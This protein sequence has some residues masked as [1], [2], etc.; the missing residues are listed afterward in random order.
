[1]AVVVS[2]LSS[3]RSLVLKGVLD[4]QLNSTAKVEIPLPENC[5]DAA[6]VQVYGADGVLIVPGATTYSAKIVD[7]T[8]AQTVSGDKNVP[9]KVEITAGTGN[10]ASGVKIIVIAFS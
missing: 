8:V 7:Q 6:V 5:L 9:G 1:M 2:K 4:A 3:D 10:L